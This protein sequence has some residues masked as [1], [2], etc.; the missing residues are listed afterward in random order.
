MLTSS[1]TT[2]ERTIPNDNVS[3][4]DEFNRVTPARTGKDLSL[5]EVEVYNATTQETERNASSSSIM[6]DSRV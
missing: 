2:T 6:A 1:S 5:G 3:E 4:M